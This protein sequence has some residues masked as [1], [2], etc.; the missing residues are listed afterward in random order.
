M[1][2]C[3]CLLLNAFW[4]V[5]VTPGKGWDNYFNQP[6]KAQ[7]PVE[8]G[9]TLAIILLHC[10]METYCRHLLCLW[11]MSAAACLS[12][13]GLKIIFREYH[14]QQILCCILKYLCSNCSS[15][16]YYSEVFEPELGPKSPSLEVL[17]IQWLVKKEIHEYTFTKLTTMST[18]NN[19]P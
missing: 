18:V 2:F 13:E 3:P 9:F 1:F 12:S 10:W 4:G 8:S 14:K 17:N 6:N 11:Y 7:T 16:T 19:S 15:Q 5:S